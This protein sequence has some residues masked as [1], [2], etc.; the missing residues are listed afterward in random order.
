MKL[1]KEQ[2]D[3]LPDNLKQYFV[4]IK[5]GDASSDGIRKNTHPT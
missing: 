1:S 2:Y 4:E 3:K 5:G